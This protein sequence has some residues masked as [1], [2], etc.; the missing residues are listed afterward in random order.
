MNLLVFRFSSLGD[1]ALVVPALKSVLDTHP[2]VRI[3]LVTRPFFFP[4]FEEL[5]RLKLVALHTKAEHKGFLGLFRLF[6]QL[7][8]QDKFDAIID[9]HNVLRTK[10][11]RLMFAMLGKRA[12]IY[13]K[14]RKGRAELTAKSDKIRKELTHTVEEYLNVFRKAGLEVS[15]SPPPWR[16]KRS[17]FKKELI[18]FAPL[19][20]NRQKTWPIRHARTLLERLNRN[21]DVR[22]FGGPDERKT[23]HELAEDLD[24]VI[25][26]PAE[27]GLAA[28]LDRISELRCMIT[29]DSANLHLA[30]IQGVPT[31]SIWG[32]THPDAGFRPLGPDHT[33]LQRS[34]EELPC[35]P[36]S[37]YGNKR[38]HRGD[39][40]CMERLEPTEVEKALIQNR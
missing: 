12:F 7:S 14:N 13:R 10:V 23:L 30:A 9:L 11:L 24:R 18:G 33:I 17:E 25:V 19:A 5:P 35:R 16:T 21:Y 26:V 40:A 37:I 29:M 28:D 27:G 1:V 34:V 36:C 6:R 3:T 38:C 32:A 8:D 15:L 39:W 22:L 31:I 4:L 20:S 2:G